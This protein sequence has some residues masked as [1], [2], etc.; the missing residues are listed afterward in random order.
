MK[1]YGIDFLF[2]A[3]F[4]LPII[5]GV[6][7]GFRANDLMKIIRGIEES[8]CFVTSFIITINFLNRSYFFD[9]DFIQSI[10]INL[11]NFT[12]KYPQ[13]S[14]YIFL[15]ISIIIIYG[16]C[17]I[18][19]FIL[20]LLIFKPLLTK[21]ENVWDNGGNLLKGF[22][23]AIFR[24]PQGIIMALLFG[25]I[26]HGVVSF[27]PNDNLSTLVN[28]SKSYKYFY[29]KIFNPISTS[30]FARALPNL[31]GDSIKVKI[32]KE[33]IGNSN[34]SVESNKIVNEIVYYNGIT[35]EEGIKSN[36]EIDNMA[37]EITRKRSSDK[38]KAKAI[39]AWVGSNV[40]YDYDKA[41]EIL[42]DNFRNKSGA[43]VTFKDRRGICFD[44]ACLFTAMARA[45]ALKVRVV[46]GQ[47]F[48]GKTWVAH[49]WNEVY[50]K[51]EDRWINVDP[52]F[53]KGGNYFDSKDFFEDHKKEKVIG[54][55]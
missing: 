37:Y 35:L 43:I 44:Y 39:Y 17:F 38:E 28:N 5:F 14:Y 6:I 33:Q 53:Y 7:R 20:N 13:I 45:S 25:M 48:D 47:G 26:V 42:N 4:L 8:I 11:S 55:W 52:T 32:V 23:G 27:V 10:S 9:I 49:A 18:P 31:I 54:E 3:C 24:I 21:V 19:F 15:L 41:T 40:E 12:E 50:L 1:D 22:I 2:L 46:I 30:N 29:S 16:I 34:G 51:E 36:S